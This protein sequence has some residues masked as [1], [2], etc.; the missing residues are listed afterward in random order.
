MVIA[1]LLVGGEVLASSPVGDIRRVPVYVTERGVMAEPLLTTAQA[2]QRLGLSPRTLETW[3]L[4]GL[5]GPTFRKL[6][7]RTVR[8]C[9]ADLVK[10]VEESGCRNTGQAIL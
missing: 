2:A 5:Y 9:E 3:R 8:Y 4:R 1:S 6:G 7:K 10:F